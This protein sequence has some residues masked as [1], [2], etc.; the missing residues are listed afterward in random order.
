M[1]KLNKPKYNVISNAVKQ[2]HSSISNFKKESMVPR[3]K[4]KIGVLLFIITLFLAVTPLYAQKS[5]SQLQKEKKENIN[6]IKAAQAT[7]QKTSAEKE[8]SIGQLNAYK[9]QINAQSN[10][11]ANYKSEIKLLENEIAL[12][13]QIINALEKDVDD[14]KAEY[15]AMVY[16]AYKASKGQDKL[17]FLFSASTFNQFFRRIHYLNQYSEARQKQVAQINAVKEMLSTQINAIEVKKTEQVSL[18]KSQVNEKEKLEELKSKEQRAIASLG[19]REKEIKAEIKKRNK[20]LATLNKLIDN[21]IKNEIA[22]ATAAAAKAKSNTATASTA[23][24][25]ADFAKNKTK[26]PWPVNG[27]V[28]QKFGISKDPI[29][30]GVEHNNPGIEIQT[31]PSSEVKAVSA[32]KVSKVV[33]IQGFN[34]AVIINHG[35]YYSV[36]AK[37][38][39]VIVKKDQVLKPGDNIGTVHTRSDGIAELHFEIWKS[40]SKLNPEKWL[41]SK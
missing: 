34:R 5:K 17:T 37:L 19:S 40:F 7:L 1:Q 33:L 20:S 16:A 21:I 35:D 23:T 38:D 3:H 13:Q 25:S 2:P 18:L 28:S 22:A 30:K 14:L 39:K 10:L 11:I 12:D 29:L 41:K 9:F 36:Y 26:L 31:K 15:G 32:G 6:R 4:A 24:L 27:F 8:I